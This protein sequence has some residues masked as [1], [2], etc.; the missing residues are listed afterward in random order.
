M[1]QPKLAANVLGVPLVDH[2][3]NVV[4]EFP[5]LTNVVVLGANQE[6]IASRASSRQ[7]NTVLNEDWADG[8]ASSLKRGLQY[9][10]EQY[11]NSLRGVVVLLGDMPF[12]TAD[13]VRAIIGEAEKE[14]KGIIVSD[15]GDVHG[16][17]TLFTSAYFADLMKLE[18]DSG[19]KELLRDNP[20]DVSSVP[21]PN[22]KYDIDTPEDL[23]RIQSL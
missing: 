18:G 6:L 21:F 2:V 17:P 15:Y 1:G 3:L 16:P 4:E 13:L 12:V 11:G 10:Q 8:M 19:G 23:E 9:L 14:G 20:S 5:E 22:G 7:L